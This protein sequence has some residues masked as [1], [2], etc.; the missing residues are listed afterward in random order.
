MA[1]E[2][3]G[4]VTLDVWSDY[5]CPFCWLAEPVVEEVR[6][7]RGIHIRRRGLELR[8]L[9]APLPEPRYLRRLWDVGVVP[10]ARS[11]GVRAAF[12]AVYPRTRM[13]HEAVAFADAAGRGEAMRQAIYEAYFVRGQDIGRVE[14]LTRLADRVGLDPYSLDVALGNDA[15]ADAVRADTEAGRALGIRALPAFA[16]HRGDDDIVRTGWC[17]AEDLGRWLN[18]TF[19]MERA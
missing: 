1:E 4:A 14:V 7:T 13:A 16:V 18:E 3:Q 11:L 5:V 9:P 8:P 10:I 19:Q 6:R 17:S 2:S 12:P 15:C